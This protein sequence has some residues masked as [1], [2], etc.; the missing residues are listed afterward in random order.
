MTAFNAK[1]NNDLHDSRSS[2]FNEIL[3]DDGNPFYKHSTSK[4]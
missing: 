2:S 1:E 3:K 4:K